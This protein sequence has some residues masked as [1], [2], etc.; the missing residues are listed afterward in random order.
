MNIFAV[1]KAQMEN[2]DNVQTDDYCKQTDENSK[3]NYK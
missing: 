3:I 1:P 2:V